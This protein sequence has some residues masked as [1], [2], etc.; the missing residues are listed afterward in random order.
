V[1]T[2]TGVPLSFLSGRPALGRKKEAIWV[3]TPM[4]EEFLI[5][6]A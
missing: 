2:T 6:P 5:L 3:F 1:A 4:A